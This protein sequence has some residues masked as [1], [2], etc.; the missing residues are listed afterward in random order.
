MTSPGAS[1]LNHGERV[2]LEERLGMMRDLLK[3][4]GI[5]PLEGRV[6]LDVGCGHGT[7]LERLAAWG[8]T[9]T[10]LHGVDASADRIGVGRSLHTQ[11]NLQCVS[12]ATLP[13][14]S[15][16]FDLVLL[17]TVMTSVLD[18]RTANDIASEVRRVLKPGGS[19]LWYDFR[20][21]SPTNRRTRPVRKKEIARYFSGFEGDF[22][23]LTILPPLIRRL[24]HLAAPVYAV[25]RVFPFLR[26]HYMAILTKPRPREGQA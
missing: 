23:K 7:D 12:A 24:G 14:P 16:M 8:A 22:R 2:M 21:R 4:H 6:I 13:F 19:V 20:R 5:F 11:I 3:K 25:L 18:E 9:R 17:C 10:N 15:G 26:T 1:P